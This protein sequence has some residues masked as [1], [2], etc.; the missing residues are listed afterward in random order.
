VKKEAAPVATAKKETAPA[1][2]VAQVEKPSAKA[3]KPAATA[4]KPA[5]K[6]KGGAYALLVGDF[7]PDPTF[8]AVQAKLK[9]CGIAPLRKSTITAPEPMNRLFVAQFTD[10]DIAEAE[11][12]KL[13]KLTA[14]AFLIADNGTYSLFA[15]SYFTESKTAS[16][17]KRLNAK[18]VTPV[19]KKA[20]ISIKVTRLT[21]GSYA[22]SAEARRD[23]LRLKK[24]GVDVRVIAAGA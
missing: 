3:A 12:Q 1:K 21:A 16:E 11:L 13:K 18:G 14:D 24:Q 4:K 15:G 8:Q 23:A 19:V 20:R 9:K 5:A 2:Q 6:H 10:Q 7:V 22:T 17:L